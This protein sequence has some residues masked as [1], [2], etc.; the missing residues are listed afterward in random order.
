MD[1]KETITL[2]SLTEPGFCHGAAGILSWK[3]QNQDSAVIS[4]QFS[5]LLGEEATPE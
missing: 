2:L 5:F 4:S 1:Y 3:E